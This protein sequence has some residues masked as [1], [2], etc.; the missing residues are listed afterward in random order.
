MEKCCSCDE[1][2]EYTRD[3]IYYCGDHARGQIGSSELVDLGFEDL[4]DKD[5]P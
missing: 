5:D 4:E 3:G 1:E 2:A